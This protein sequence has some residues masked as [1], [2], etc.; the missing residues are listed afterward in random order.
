MQAGSGE[1]RGVHAYK[2]IAI[3]HQGL[4]AERRHWKPLLLVSPWHDVGQEELMDHESG[5]Y[6]PGIPIRRS[7]LYIKLGGAV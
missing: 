1:E 3:V 7:I 6:L 2:S 4:V 5:V